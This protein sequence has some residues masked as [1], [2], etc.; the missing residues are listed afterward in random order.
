MPNPTTVFIDLDPAVMRWLFAWLSHILRTHISSLPLPFTRNLEL[1]TQ[2]CFYFVLCTLYF[3]L[4]SAL[5]RYLCSKTPSLSRTFARLL[6]SGS[7]FPHLPPP[8]PLHR[9]QL[10][11]TVAAYSSI[12]IF[13]LNVGGSPPNRSFSA[14]FSRKRVNHLIFFRH[15]ISYFSSAGEK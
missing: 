1:R 15:R 14:K 10:R 11:E 12:V 13:S 6:H 9:R 3:A 7:S 4:Q 2:D 5:S 8:H